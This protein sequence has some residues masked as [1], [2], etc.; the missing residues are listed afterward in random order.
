MKRRTLLGIVLALVACAAPPKPASDV[1]AIVDAPDR[2]RDDKALDALRRPT[3]L[4]TFI[5]LAPGMKVAELGSVYGYTAELL[6]RAV[7]PTGRVF[8]HNDDFLMKTYAEEEVARRL[9]KPVNENLVHVVRPFDDPFPPEARDLDAVVVVNVYHTTFKIRGGVDRA[10]MNA[11]VLRALK[12]GGS[13]TVIDHSAKEG[14]GSTQAATL[15]RIEEAFVRKEVQAA[16]F[17]LAATSDA[18]R[19]V[20]DTRDWD[21]SSFSLG[22]AQHGRPD[23]FAL[24]FVKP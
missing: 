9:A 15:N 8:M 23:A 2:D 3:E 17:E 5:A 6:G 13:Y 18:F 1:R 4:L 16:G 21:A 24:R 20:S 7:G 10:K 22:G 11:A 19:N 12:P 14:A